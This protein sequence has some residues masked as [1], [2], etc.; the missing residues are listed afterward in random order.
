M[1][2]K[3]LKV[4]LDPAKEGAFRATFSGLNVVDSDN[5][6]TLPGA[7]KSG[8]PVRIAQWGHNWSGPVI[9]AGLLGADTT[10]AWA[11]AEFNLKMVAGRE[12][13]ES[14]K[15]DA[16]RHKLQQWSYGYDVLDSEMG[17]FE[18]K[19]VRF[20]KALEVHEISPVMLG[21]GVGTAT[22]FIKS[23]GLP[24]ADH[25]VH[26]LASVQAFLERTKELK[27]LRGKE[28]R[29]LSAANRTRLSGLVDAMRGGMADLEALIAAT[30]PA[31][32]GKQLAEIEA[33]RLRML[34]DEARSL[35]AA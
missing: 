23:A 35:V 33:I 10:K 3:A 22:D 11:D 14:V 27:E 28:G 20:L 9:G 6:V 7:F 30:D 18:G 4:E 29:V 5:D 34:A 31:D 1:E 15:F 21:A 13:Y 19:D 17:Q 32:A 24:Y 8:A 25:A 26:V 16:E 12:N 2:R